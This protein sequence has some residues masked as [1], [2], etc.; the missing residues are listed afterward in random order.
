[1]AKQVTRLVTGTFSP[2]HAFQHILAMQ[3]YSLPL[4]SNSYIWV[5]KNLIITDNSKMTSNY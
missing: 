1:L 2:L 3:N 4:S 5:S